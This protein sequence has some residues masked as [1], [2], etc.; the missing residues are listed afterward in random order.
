[1]PIT[2]LGSHGNSQ[3]NVFGRAELGVYAT[4]DI[5]PLRVYFAVGFGT[6]NYRWQYIR[7]TSNVFSFDLAVNPRLYQIK[8]HT[9]SLD[10]G[11]H[12]QYFCK[13]RNYY[14]EPLRSKREYRSSPGILGSDYSLLTGIRY[15][16]G[17]HKNWQL[18]FKYYAMIKRKIFENNTTPTRYFPDNYYEFHSG[19]F[20]FGFQLHLEYL[21]SKNAR[22]YYGIKAED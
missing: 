14:Q 7:T 5:N 20:A 13:I 15:S 11:F 6:Q 19:K 12:S 4:E 2:Y 22:F 9:I 10:A 16:Y 17:I 1:L 18:H 8:K 3:L 21:W